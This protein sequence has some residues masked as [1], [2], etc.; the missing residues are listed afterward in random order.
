MHELS[1]LIEFVKIAEET[2]SKN[3]IS[4]ICTLRLKIGKATG[5][6]PYYL[7]R[8][9]PSATKGTRLEGAKL[10][11]EEVPVHA[12]CEDCGL[13]YEP[14]AQNRYTCPACGSI[15]AKLT[16]GRELLVEAIEGSAGTS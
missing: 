6:L 14:N 8:Y 10:E 3:E 1:Y 5:V 2:A 7:Q 11:I 16:G 13:E 9:F 15:R 4:K 12:A